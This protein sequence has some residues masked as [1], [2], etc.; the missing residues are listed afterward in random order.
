M[1]EWMRISPV[2]TLFPGGSQALFMGEVHHGS[3]LF[4]PMPHTL[5]GALRT[6]MLFQGG[7]RPEEFRGEGFGEDDALGRFM[8]SVETPG[9]R[10][11]GPLLCWKDS[12]LLPVPAHVYRIKG[13]G[14]ERVFLHRAEP[15]PPALKSLGVT[16]HLSSAGRWETLWAVPRKGGDLEPLAEHVMSPA[17]LPLLG[18][19]DEVEV[20]VVSRAGELD[21]VGDEPFV[22]SSSVLYA[23]EARTG[24]ALESRGRRVRQGCLFT[25]DHVRLVEGAALMAGIESSRGDSLWEVL[26]RRGVLQLGGEN[27]PVTYEAAEGLAMEGSEGDCWMASGPV[28]VGEIEALAPSL[29]AVATGKVRRVGGW[30]MKADP[31]ARRSKGFHRPVSGWYAAGCVVWTREKTRLGG[32]WLV[33]SGF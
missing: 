19:R 18:K 12:P 15:S 13:S 32:S 28:A 22:A 29:R 5:A 3:S 11:A 23:T 24:I 27:R 20:K 21:E 30:K 17:V 7:R 33:V 25:L 4:P 31:R 1:M 26:A 14:G 10:L 16:D 9:F 2:D 6:A 8:G